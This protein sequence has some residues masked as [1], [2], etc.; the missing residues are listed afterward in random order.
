MSE[1]K[2]SSS[3]DAIVVIV[4][5]VRVFVML[6]LWVGVFLAIFLGYFTIP[7][8]LISLIAAG[9]LISDLGLFVTLKKRGKR[10]SEHQEFI[11]SIKGDSLQK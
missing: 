6:V 10:R 9:Y 3:A 4:I 1:N 8:L 11:D 7:F 2:P 5:L